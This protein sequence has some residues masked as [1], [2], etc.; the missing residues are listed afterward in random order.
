MSNL[1]SEHDMAAAKS[2]NQRSEARERREKVLQLLDAPADL[3][4]KELLT[5]AHQAESAFLTQLAIQITP[6]MNH[7]LRDQPHNTYEEKKTLAKWLNAELGALAL[8]VQ[9]PRSGRAGCLVGDIG[10][11][12]VHGRFQI[13]VA[14][15]DGKRRRTI[16]GKTLL[17]RLELEF[18]PD[19]PRIPDHEVGARALKWGLSVSGPR[20]RDIGR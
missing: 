16:S 11:D 9:C 19:F 4:L 8:S 7:Y 1:K 2:D 5:L 13:N 18:V 10:K 6:A 17:E 12:P 14:T 3:S 20:T 15:E